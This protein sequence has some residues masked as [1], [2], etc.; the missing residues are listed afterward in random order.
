MAVCA[1]L[2][3]VYAYVLAARK[4]PFIHRRQ[5]LFFCNFEMHGND[6][7]GV[8]SGLHLQAAI[9]EGSRADADDRI[10]IN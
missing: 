2:S 8:E 1:L 9:D 3:D 5:R 4:V 7:K 6:Q 10:E